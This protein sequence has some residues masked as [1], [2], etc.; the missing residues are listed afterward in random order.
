MSIIKFLSILFS[1][2]FVAL[3]VREASAS[4]Q[5]TLLP[6]EAVTIVTCGITSS[7]F[8]QIEILELSD[9]RFALRTLDRSGSRKTFELPQRQWSI[10][11]VMVPC[12]QSS[13]STCGELQSTN[14]HDWSYVITGTSGTAI[15]DCR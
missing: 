13:Q 2:G 1:A 5:I 11:R 14:G 8:Q 15:G 10:R 6:D 12:Y 7:D 9:G 4:K 3:S